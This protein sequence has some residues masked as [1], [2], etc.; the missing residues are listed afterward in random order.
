M[1]RK[2]ILNLLICVLPL[3]SCGSS[4]E[5]KL[6]VPPDEDAFQF[7][8]NKTGGNCCLDKIPRDLNGWTG[9]V[10]VKKTARTEGGHRVELF[11]VEIAKNLAFVS[12]GNDDPKVRSDIP[13]AGWY[14]KFDAVKADLPWS[15]VG[16][17]Q[18]IGKHRLVLVEIK[19][20]SV[21]APGN[22]RQG[23]G[24]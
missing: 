22:H 4:A 8:W 6:P 19:L 17:L 2:T 9:R 15:S 23:Y 24:L 10:L 20:K 3:A 21:I 14:V 5:V 12:Y 13:E 11:V 16:E 7:D 18:M 1:P